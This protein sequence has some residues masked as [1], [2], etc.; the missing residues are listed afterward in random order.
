MK[1][2]MVNSIIKGG[3]WS[4]KRYWPKTTKMGNCV[5]Q[6]WTEIESYLMLLARWL[7]VQKDGEHEDEHVIKQLD[8]HLTW[9]RHFEPDTIFCFSP[10]LKPY[11][12]IVE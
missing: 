2:L 10:P 11:L 8:S 3:V 6:G 7:V 12:W 1:A 5:V 9:K 4:L